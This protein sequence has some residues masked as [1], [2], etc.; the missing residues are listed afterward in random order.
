TALADAQKQRVQAVAKWQ[1]SRLRLAQSLGKLEPATDDTAESP[2]DEART[3][4]PQPKIRQ[5]NPAHQPKTTD[6]A[7]T[8]PGPPPLLS[9]VFFH[10]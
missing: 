10:R 9:P 6:L 3:V 8:D 4:K 2:I 5:P 1:T 7:H